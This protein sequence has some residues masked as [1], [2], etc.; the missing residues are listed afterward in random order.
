MNRILNK[1]TSLLLIIFFSTIS[2]LTQAQKV[3]SWNTYMAYSNTIMT[4]EALNK[5]FAVADGSLYSYSPEDDEIKV[6]SKSD[7]LSDVFIQQIKYDPNSKSLILIYDNLN[8]DIITESDIFNISAIKNKSITN[9]TINNIE[10]YGQYAYLSTAFGIVAIDLQK[11]EIK[12]TYQLDKDIRSV[13]VMGDYTYAATSDGVLEALNSSNLLDKGSWKY[14][15]LSHINLNDKDI[16]KLLIFQNTLVFSQYEKGIYYLDSNNTVVELNWG[17]FKKVDLVNDQIVGIENEKVTFYPDL[18]SNKKDVVQNLYI[19]DISSNSKSNIYWTAQG[20][21]G[22][23]SIKK[24]PGSTSYE[25]IKKDLAINSP[26]RNSI[27]YMIYSQNKLLIVGG[28]RWADRFHYPGTLMVLENGSWYNFNENDIAKQSGT[29]CN[30]FI[31]VVVDPLDANHYYVASYGEGL[32]EFKDNNF[33]KLYDLTNSTLESANGLPNY[34]RVDGLAF[35]KNNNLYLTNT[36]VTNYIQ[37]LKPDKTWTTQTYPTMGKK[38]TINLT[39]ITK[40]NQKWL[41]IP[42]SGPGLFVFDEKGT[43]DN[44]NDDRSYFFSS[45]SDQNGETISPSGYLCMA[46]DLNGTIWVGTDLGPILLNNPSRALDDPQNYRCYRTVVPYEEGS[47]DGYYMLENKQVNAIAIDGA[48][49]KWIGTQSSGIY[50]LNETGA[51]IIHNFTTEN[52]PLISNTIT[53]IAINDNSGEV[54]IGTDKGLVSYISEATEGKADYSDIYAYPNPVRPEFDNQVVITGLVKDS[55][56]K[57]TDLKGNL[58]YQGT[59]IGGQFVW[60]CTKASGERVNA[61]VYL[62]FAATKDGSMGVVTKIMVVK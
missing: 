6:Y 2:T 54:F 57:I 41:N 53:T 51:K 5:V 10:I 44:L 27:Y 59:S 3:G 14:F 1:K 24:E 35:D 49:R 15:P 17:A 28:G 42:R 61:G 39:L 12:N 21:N 52:S 33:V 45:F 9:K 32:Y 37:I 30:D 46:E 19:N 62:V 56:I 34:V 25:V 58:M 16:Q 29:Q 55:N 26:K 47:T 40:S 7:G 13:C 43:I 60:N 36:G 48:N 50:L 20:A 31:S 22:L 8:I 4:A 18:S 11:K 23:V 38:G